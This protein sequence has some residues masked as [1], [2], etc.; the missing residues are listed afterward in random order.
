M[1]RSIIQSVVEE[2]K[3]GASPTSLAEKWGVHPTTILRWV[4]KELNVKPKIANP[5][6]MDRVTKL[7]LRKLLENLN[8]QDVEQVISEL[9]SN[10][11]IKQKETKDED[12]EVIFVK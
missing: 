9:D 2:Y 3:L 7:E 10:F 4:K 12:F 5:S 11:N 8:I 1:N 6:N